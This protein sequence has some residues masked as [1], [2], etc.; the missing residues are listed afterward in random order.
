MTM[1]PK[2]FS[3]KNWSQ[4][5]R[6]REKLRDKGSRVLSDAELLAILIGSGTFQESAVELSKR[7]LSSV[8]HNL[9]NL[10]KLSIAQLLN[11]KG[12]GEAKAIKIKAAM[13][14]SRR[15]RESNP[16]QLDKINTS[17]SAFEIMQPLLG[18]LS[19]EEFWVL[20]LNRSNKIVA[21]TQLSKGG[22]T[23]TIVDV[24]IILKQALEH[25]ATAILLAHNHPSGMLKPSISDKQLTQKLKLASESL[26][27]KVLDHIIVTEKSYFSFADESLL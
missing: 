4:D 13:E 14:L 2:S 24:R 22:M 5:D 12:I 7:I 8:G 17:L 9:Q 11:F 16:T 6:P 10:G 25:S 26:D 18:H 15:R 20:Y 21:K 23:S 27:I 1:L 19:H 3:I